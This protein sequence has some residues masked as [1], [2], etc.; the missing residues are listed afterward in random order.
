MGL[1]YGQTS[2][3]TTGATSSATS[4]TYSPTQTGV[5]NQTGNLLSQDLSAS[6]NGALSPG[7]VAQETS[8]DD[9]I[10]TTDAGLTGRVN[11]FLAQR[12]FGP[13]GQT[14][15]ATLQGELGREGAI[16]NE[17][18]TADAQQNSMN[19]TNLLAALNYAFT[20]LGSSSA[21]ASSGTSSGSSFGANAS[22]AFSF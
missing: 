1:S 22:A 14:G 8:A 11:Q 21:G 3:A 6:A 4:G 15:Q 2:G 7:T 9:Q 5:Q 16:G 19:S 20:S 10:N 13:S 17:A 18:A 12:G